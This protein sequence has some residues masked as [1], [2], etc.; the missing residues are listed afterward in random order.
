MEVKRKMTM[1]FFSCSFLCYERRSIVERKEMMSPSLSLSLAFLPQSRPRS[2]SITLSFPVRRTVCHQCTLVIG[3]MRGFTNTQWSMTCPLHKRHILGNALFCSLK[4]SCCTQHHFISTKYDDQLCVSV[5][6]CLR[7]RRVLR[8]AQSKW[9][10]FIRWCFDLARNVLFSI[11][12][13]SQSHRN[14]C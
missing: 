10:L 4:I 13:Y 11:C 5:C 3:K 8:W 7:H 9:L 1:T 6:E 12:F 14:N 2:P